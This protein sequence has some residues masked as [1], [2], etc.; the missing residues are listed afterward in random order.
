M[1]NASTVRLWVA[2]TVATA[3]ITGPA[4]GVN[5][6]PRLSPRTKPPLASLGLPSRERVERAPEQ[7]A[8][9]R[10]DQRQADQDDDRDREVPEEVVG[11][12]ERREERSRGQREDG[13]ADDEPGDDGV[14][15]PRPP[16]AP[17]PAIGSDGGRTARRP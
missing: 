9:P 2:A 5:R 8:E 13:E 14:R 11:Q 17:L 1:R 15:P 6:S 12:P 3:A 16:V 10:P 4:Q 7:V